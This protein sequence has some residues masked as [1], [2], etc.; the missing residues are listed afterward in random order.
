MFSAMSTVN[1][2]DKIR[3]HY[4][5]R[6][7][8]G[9]VFDSSDG[10]DPLEF[11]VGAGQVI[12]GFDAGVLS[13]GAG[14]KKQVEIPAAEAYGERSSDLEFVVPREQLPEELEIE[15]GTPL[16]VQQ[17]DGSNF[18]VTISKVE[19]EDI[20]LDANHELAGQDLIFDIEIVS[21]G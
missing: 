21:I 10:R 6:L 4:T 15:V 1:K 13:M 9:T 5:G 18:M 2:G 19:G 7:R 14:E 3:V 8:D 16:Q 20:T 17:P 12:E 11:E